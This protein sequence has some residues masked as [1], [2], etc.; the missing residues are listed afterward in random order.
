MA[1]RRL[2]ALSMMTFLL[3]VGVTKGEYDIQIDIMETISLA[4]DCGLF[5]GYITTVVEDTA[6]R[7]V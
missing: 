6:C 7:H 3:I 5:Y 2:V 4:Q 1:F